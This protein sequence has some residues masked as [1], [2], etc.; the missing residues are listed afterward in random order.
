M[1]ILSDH[2]GFL[3][4]YLILIDLWEFHGV[5]EVLL[6]VPLVDLELLLSGGDELDDLFALVPGEHVHLVLGDFLLE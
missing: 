6:P 4:S 1:Y 5:A 2:G 3:V